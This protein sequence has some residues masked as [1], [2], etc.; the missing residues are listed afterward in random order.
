M[1]KWPRRGEEKLMADQHLFEEANLAMMHF[2]ASYHKSVRCVQTETDF[3]GM[4]SV[5]KP[6]AEKLFDAVHYTFKLALKNSPYDRMPIKL[7]LEVKVNWL[8][9]D[10]SDSN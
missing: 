5:D 2:G 10:K 8:T 1:S 4:E 9:W 6:L 7:R 3:I